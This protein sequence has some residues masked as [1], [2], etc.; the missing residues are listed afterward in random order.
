MD[1]VDLASDLINKIDD[2]HNAQNQEI[3]TKL[4]EWQDTQPSV[5]KEDNLRET[6]NELRMF[7]RYS[8]SETEMYIK[9]K[10]AGNIDG[11][12]N[13]ETFIIVKAA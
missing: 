6:I 3:K 12:G 13:A 4:R 8:V 7:P 9:V 2:M 10:V 5:T 11:T 1:N